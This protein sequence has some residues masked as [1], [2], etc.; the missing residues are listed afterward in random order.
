[1]LSARHRAREQR[2]VEAIK[3]DIVCP[4]VFVGGNHEDYDYLL[5]RQAA[6]EE[7]LLRWTISCQ[8]A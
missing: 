5:R 3:T 1:M 7:E 2:L 8:R 6:E 4:V